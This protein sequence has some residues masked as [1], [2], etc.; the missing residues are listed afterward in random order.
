MSR[1]R[2]AIRLVSALRP[3]GARRSRSSGRLRTRSRPHARWSRCHERRLDGAQSRAEGP[4]LPAPGAGMSAKRALVTGVTGQDA[5][6]RTELLLEKGYEVFGVTRRAST[7][8]LERIEHLIHRITLLQGD[9]LDPSSIEAAL[10][11]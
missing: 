8:N 9:L 2:L 6:Y 4:A 5:S 10:R 11:A 7:E 1:G 3:A